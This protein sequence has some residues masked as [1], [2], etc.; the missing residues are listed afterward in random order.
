MTR[1]L[2]VLALM[3]VAIFSSCGKKENKNAPQPAAEAPAAAQPAGGPHAFVYLKDGSR[4]P[5]TIVA[6][7]QTDMVVAGDDGIE[8][9]IPLVQVKSVEY[10]DA[11]KAEPAQKAASEPARLPQPAP[12]QTTQ[13]APLP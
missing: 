7:S 5:G 3:G 2:A 12:G 4:V 8:R 1:V 6:S 11:P 13:P 10:G 9:K